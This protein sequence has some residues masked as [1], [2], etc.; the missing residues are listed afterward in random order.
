[1]RR[2][3]GLCRTA[4]PDEYP[5]HPLEEEQK[6]T[7]RIKLKCNQVVTSCCFFV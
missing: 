6:K 4:T 7:F 3:S 5:R 2:I 1:M